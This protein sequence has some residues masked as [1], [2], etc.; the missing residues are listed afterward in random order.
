MIVVGMPLTLEPTQIKD[1][2]N[3]IWLFLLALM[4]VALALS[5]ILL[6]T[7]ARWTTFW[8]KVGG[9]SR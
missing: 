9:L 4:V 1:S 5:S 6:V 7:A 3:M 8:T 2:E